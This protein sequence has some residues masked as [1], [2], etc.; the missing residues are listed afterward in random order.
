MV[1]SPP[2]TRALAHLLVR[3][4]EPNSARGV[5]ELVITVVPFVVIWALM[6]TALDH[7]Y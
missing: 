5:F 7:G 1:H 6:W 4:R 3:Y 2:E